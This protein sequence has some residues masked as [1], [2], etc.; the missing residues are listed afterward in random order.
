M[1]Y[2]KA[3]AEL[4][5]MQQDRVKWA[6]RRVRKERSNGLDERDAASQRDAE[7]RAF[8]ILKWGLPVFIVVD[9]AACLSVPIGPMRVGLLISAVAISALVF[10][11][12]AL[13]EVILFWTMPDNSAEPRM[14]ERES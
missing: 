4:N 8:R 10:V 11:V 3:Y 5:E 13:P 7:R 2:G 14:L 12:L 6:V 9:W 1:A